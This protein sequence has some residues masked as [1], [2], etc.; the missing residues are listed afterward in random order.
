MA[1]AMGTQLFTQVGRQLLADLS[2]Y[3][4]PNVENFSIAW[5]EA[6]GEGNWAKYLDGEIENYAYLSILDPNGRSIGQG[7]MEF[8]LEQDHGFFCTYWNSLYFIHPEFRGKTIAG[9]PDHIW[10][11]IPEN[12]KIKYKTSRM[13]KLMK[14]STTKK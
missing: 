6:E 3:G 4:I 2:F 5:R 9:I 1:K 12:A 10:D 13:K 8:I 14:K 11:K 7:S